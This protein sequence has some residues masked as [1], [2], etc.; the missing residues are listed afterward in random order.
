MPKY[1]INRMQSSYESGRQ[2]S[3]SRAEMI[4]LLAMSE[5]TLGVSVSVSVT[6]T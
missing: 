2:D 1:E 3:R 6:S 4:N 5:V